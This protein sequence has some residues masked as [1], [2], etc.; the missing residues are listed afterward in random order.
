LQY[1]TI[2]N[3]PQTANL[4][5]PVSSINNPPYNSSLSTIYLQIQNSNGYYMQTCSFKQS[6]P[7]QLR[8]STS[9]LIQGWNSQI[10]ATSNVTFA[11]STY[12]VPFTNNIVWIHD[13]TLAISP[14]YP[15]SFTVTN[16]SSNQLSSYISGATAIGQSLSFSATISNPPTTQ[17]LSSTMY[18]VYSSTLFI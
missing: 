5:I 16:Y 2:T 11:L 14:L 17:P 7:T 13:Q 9:L 15:T 10:G 8:S 12:F 1:L 3:V 18:V 6:A 4:L